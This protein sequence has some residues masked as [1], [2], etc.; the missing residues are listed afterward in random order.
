MREDSLKNLRLQAFARKF[1][2]AAQYTKYN[3]HG[4]VLENIDPNGVVTTNTYD[5]RQRL[6]STTVGNRT[7]AY[8]YD[9]VGQLK[10]VTLPD[11][12]WIGYDYDDAHRQ[13]AVYDHK[14][15]RVDY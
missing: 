4:Q 5:L 13:V 14:G 15:N 12:R 7:T 1:A 2:C 6:L 3:K 11:T 9:P 8:Q 10:R